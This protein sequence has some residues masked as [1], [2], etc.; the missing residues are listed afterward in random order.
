[1]RTAGENSPLLRD[2]ARYVALAYR[3]LGSRADAEDVVQEAFLRAAGAAEGAAE[4]ERYLFRTVANL[5]VDRLRA[6][7]VRRRA[8]HGPWLPEPLVSDDEPDDVADLAENLSIGFLLLLERL[9]PG[10]RV[11]FVLREAFDLEFGEIADL[12]GISAEACRQRH[13]R[14][15]RHLRGERREA[16]SQTVQ[17]RLLE[18]LMTAVAEQRVDAVVELLSD[19]VLLLTDG[20]GVVAAAIRPV[21]GRERIAR[22]LVHLAARAEAEA[23]LTMRWANVNGA[24]GVL[25]LCDGT[26]HSALTVDASETAVRRIFVIRNPN[27]LAGV[28]VPGNRA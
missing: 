2:R 28:I 6:E 11:V 24:W 9:S 10:E 26:I 27:K 15:R 3:M 8:Y 25:L 12:L 16:P 7:R 20:G 22:V 17:R 19:D 4:P 1:M 5:C 18:R 13:S 14:A 21:E 23:P